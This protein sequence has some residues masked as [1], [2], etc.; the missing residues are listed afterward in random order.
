MEVIT[1]QEHFSEVLTHLFN[2]RVIKLNAYEDHH[3]NIP[4]VQEDIAPPYMPES[5]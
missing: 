4:E 3:Q 5:I 1:F 2:L